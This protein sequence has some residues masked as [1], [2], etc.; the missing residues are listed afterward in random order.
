[1]DQALQGQGHYGTKITIVATNGDF[2][3][4]ALKRR[5]ELR[6]EGFDIRLWNGAFLRMLLDKWPAYNANLK[7]LRP[8]QDRIVKKIIRN[9]E[10]GR[11]KVF[12]SLQQ[13]WEKQLLLRPQQTFL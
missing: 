8:Y 11:K 7:K 13:A 1:M 12:L 2:T 10:G 5:D 6:K 9:F 4:S 3:N